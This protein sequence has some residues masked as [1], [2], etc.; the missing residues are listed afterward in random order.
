MKMASVALLSLSAG[1]IGGYAAFPLLH[2]EAAQPGHAA[3]GVPGTSR[4]VVACTLSPEQIEHLSSRIAPA[5]VER[6]ATSGLPGVA[7]D[8]NVA[9]RQRVANENLQKEQA[10][11]YS[12]AVKL[13]DQMIASHNVTPQGKNQAYELLR[14]T[15][16]ADRL[17]E[18]EARISAAINRGDLTPEQAGLTP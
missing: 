1:A 17:F 10:A 2:D 12:Q 15:S 18:I 13:V 9:A 7:P 6:L 3:C 5:V 4:D 14:Q 8:A 11:A 16:Q